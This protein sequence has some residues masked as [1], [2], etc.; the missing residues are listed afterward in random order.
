MTREQISL[1]TCQLQMNGCGLLASLRRKVYMPVLRI[2][3]EEKLLE[4]D[5]EMAESVKD[6]MTAVET[7]S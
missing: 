1:T 6:H 2:F 7:L 5:L 4:R 3:G